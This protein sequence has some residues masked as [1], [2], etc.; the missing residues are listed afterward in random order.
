MRAVGF[1]A[2]HAEAITLSGPSDARAAMQFAAQL[3]CRLLLDRRY[4]VAGVSREGQEWQIVLA[5]PLINP[6]LGDW[7]EAGRQVLKLVNI[8][9]AKD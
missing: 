4:S 3:N 8:A 7:Q 6:D 5:Q 9:R 1:I 2:A